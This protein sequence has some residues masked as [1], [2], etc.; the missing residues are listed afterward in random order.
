MVL[1]VAAKPRNKRLSIYKYIVDNLADTYPV[2]AHGA[3]NIFSGWMTKTT[4]DS[5]SAWIEL[6]IESYDGGQDS[7]M[8]VIFTVATRPSKQ[9]AD[10]MG[11]Q[12]DEM[13]ESIMSLLNFPEGE[14]ID[15]YDFADPA[16]PVQIG[17]AD[18]LGFIVRHTPE[19]DR[20]DNRTPDLSRYQMHYRLFL[21]NEGVT[22]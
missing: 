5:L 1:P 22:P 13:I 9:D 14:V 2:V 12:A 6:D 8:R 19:R 18:G 20:F 10:Y 16:N 15:V 4:L 17:A 7:K 21:W 11:K 3:T